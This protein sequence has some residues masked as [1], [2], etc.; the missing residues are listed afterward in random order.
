[1]AFLAIVAIALFAPSALRP[2]SARLRWIAAAALLTGYAVG[3]SA[4]RIV[5][6]EFDTLTRFGQQTGALRLEL[7]WQAW[8][9]ALQHPLLGLGVGQ[10]AAGQY[11]VARPSAFVVP[12]TNCHNL[13]LELAAEFGW[14]AALAVCSL[15]VYW[16]LRDLRVRLAR[17]ESA[18][19]MG[20]L[21]LIAIHSMLEFPLWHLYFALPATLLFAL[22]EPQ[23]SAARSLDVRRIL[24]AAGLA[25]LG[26]GLALNL[27]Y[28]WV[29]QAATPMWLEAKNIRKRVPEDA[30]LVISVA[31]SKM[32]QPEVDR[33]MIDLNHPPDEHTAGPILRAARVLRVLPAPEVITQYI[34]LLAN[35]GRIDDAMTH[36]R[37]LRVLGHAG[38]PAYRDL[39]LERTREL[40]PQTAPLRHL[41]RQAL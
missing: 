32:F 25:I 24:P 31:D 1:M 28:H 3:L 38:Y 26:V 14:P 30:L 21:L 6:G 40:G 37:R 15:G 35:A 5:V 2:Q 41:L 22:A 20:I 23:W 7:W 29:S 12:A 36:L 4:V 16:A 39:I 27:N 11:W 19:A 18:L 8:H 9:I 17:P 13:V 34:I 10:F 33:L